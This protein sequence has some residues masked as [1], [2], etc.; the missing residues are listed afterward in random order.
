MCSMRG[1]ASLCKIFF[2]AEKIDSACLLGSKDSHSMFK[3]SLFYAVEFV[4]KTDSVCF[5]NL[6]EVKKGGIIFGD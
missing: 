6:L 4:L 3:A 1:K 2:S 5:D